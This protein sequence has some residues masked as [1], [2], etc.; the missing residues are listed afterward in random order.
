M[1]WEKPR[2]FQYLNSVEQNAPIQW[3]GSFPSLWTWQPLTQATAITIYLAL[4]STP[5]KRWEWL[6][7]QEGKE[8]NGLVS[9]HTMP[10]IIRHF[11]TS[12]SSLVLTI[13]L[14][15]RFSFCIYCRKQTQMSPCHLNI[16]KY[17]F[18]SLFFYALLYKKILLKWP[19]QFWRLR[20]V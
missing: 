1:D 3:S 5:R 13:A 20:R 12:V 18:T 14:R 7:N 15:N 17:S 10:G 2:Q 19:V 6:M 9:A 16:S 4:H 11:Y 8:G